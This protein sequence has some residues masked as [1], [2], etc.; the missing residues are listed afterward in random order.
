MVIDDKERER[1]KVVLTKPLSLNEESDSDYGAPNL[2]QR[3]LSLFK[4]V[5][6][7]SDLTSF[8]LPPLFNFPKS[9]LQCY[10]ESVYS[11][12]SDMLS[13]CSKAE[14]PIDRFIAVVGWSISTLRPLTFG[15]APY[16][17]VLG[18][19]HHVSRGN[20]H[21]LLEQVSHHPPVSALHATDEKEN[22][23]L[24]WTH[25]AVPKFYGTSV[26]TEVHGRRQLNLLTRNETYEMNSPK[27]LI[28]FLPFPGV[29]WVGNVKICCHE[30]GLEADLSFRATSFLGLRK[31][32]RSVKGKI[33]H[34]SSP[35]NPLFEINGN[36]DRTVTAKDVNN[37]GI[38]VIFDAKE[39]LTGLKTPAVKD[40]KGVWRG[41]SAAVWGEVSEGIMRGDWKKAR[42]AKM[43][44]EEKQREMMREREGRGQTWVPKHFSLSCSKDGVWECCPL[45]KWV[46]P[47]PI[48]SPI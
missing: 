28:R 24:I 18:E 6:P 27:L 41:E 22:I 8:Q 42:E 2:L 14:T 35:N 46:P 10:G 5:R 40:L 34:R 21:V 12:S 32:H 15:V 23:E 44:V 3:L 30:T 48:V 26:E 37:G 33:H 39:A 13:K 4:N 11:I 38:T 25:H 20:L 9:H 36:W 29:D 1:T 16:N 43:A 31:S 45:Q 47:A 19:T 17:P 7:G